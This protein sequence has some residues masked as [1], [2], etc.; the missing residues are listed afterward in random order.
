MGELSESR[1]EVKRGEYWANM[2]EHVV[3]GDV[4]A[5][6]DDGEEGEGSGDGGGRVGRV[7]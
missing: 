7:I 1:P 5:V 3:C 2:T 6:E 4:G